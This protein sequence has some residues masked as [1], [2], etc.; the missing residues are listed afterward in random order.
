MKP[1]GARTSVTTTLFPGFRPGMRISPFSTTAAGCEVG[2]DGVIG[3]STLTQNGIFT[4]AN[5]RPVRICDFEL[6]VLQG[7]AGVGGAD[8]A[9]EQDAVR[10]VVEANRDNALSSAVGQIDGLGGVDDAVA[11]RREK[12]YPSR[13]KI[14]RRAA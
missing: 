7:D 13:S 11:I 5:Q 14:N 9:D 2:L 4:T 6:S 12:Q 8:L 10:G 3:T 1:A